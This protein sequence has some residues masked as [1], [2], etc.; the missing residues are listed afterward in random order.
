MSIASMVDTKLARQQAQ[1]PTQISTPSPVGVSTNVINQITRWIP[2]ETITVYVALLALVAPLSAHSPSYTSRWVLFA[3]ITVATPIVVILLNMAKTQSGEVFKLPFFEMII[4]TIAF[5]A[6][7]FALPETPL[8][9]IPGYG[10][11]WNTAILTVTTVGVTLVA[12]ALH[13]SPD[14]DQIVTK[15]QGANPASPETQ[16]ALQQQRHEQKEQQMQQLQQELQLQ[17][18]QPQQQLPQQA[19]PQL[20]PAAP[21]PPAQPEH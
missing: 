12:N 14:Y 9:S 21:P 2:T 17:Q 5:A 3:I 4:A 6:W 19:Q 8:G 10:I 13:K 11:Q 15:D 1:D 7:A 18:A 16:H 20:P